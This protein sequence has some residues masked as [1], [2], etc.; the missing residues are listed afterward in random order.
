MRRSWREVLA[1]E[2]SGTSIVTDRSAPPAG[3]TPSGELYVVTPGR[4]RRRVMK[5][6]GLTI[7]T[8]DGPPPDPQDAPLAR[9]VWLASH[10]R[11]LIE[12]TAR[13]RRTRDGSQPRTLSE[14]EIGDWIDKIASRSRGTENLL[15]V[16]NEIDRLS[17]TG[18]YAGTVP[19]VPSRLIGAAL[20]T[21]D[22]ETGSL[23][24]ASRI[25]GR[26][27]DAHRVELFDRLADRLARTAPKPLSAPDPT[28]AQLVPF[29]EAYFSNFIEG[30][31][32]TI[33]E[34]YDVVFNGADLDRPD[35]A[36]DVRGTWR[37]TSN[38]DEMSNLA[39]T[40]NEFCDM[41]RRRHTLV[42]SSRTDK[43]PGEFKDRS[44]R[45]GGI[46]FVA[47]AEVKETLRI[48]WANLDRIADSF[49]RACY[50]MFLIAEV[51]PFV[52]GNGRVARLF[53]N[54]ELVA[55]NQ[56][57]VIIPT[58]YRNNYLAALSGVSHD[59]NP[60]ALARVLSFA[61]QWVSAGEWDNRD[62]AERYLHASDAY[63]TPAAEQSGQARLRIPDPADLHGIDPN[64][65]PDSKRR[66]TAAPVATKAL[67]CGIQTRNMKGPCVLDRGHQ[68]GHSSTGRQQKHR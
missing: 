52:D 67:R 65:L 32:F 26:P 7:L 16:R 20:G 55:A 13:S 51:H 62:R 28:R 59:N 3:P 9:N 49:Q 41:L 8:R 17:A 64:D 1:H 23:R 56:P 50:T 40:S 21:R 57:R 11:A 19:E 10:A 30:T 2:V 39:A 48:G 33:D 46:E 47:P 58:V 15:H 27:F 38:L 36:H 45:V 61:Q 34:A 14:T 44:N 54:A 35:D 12:N 68:N 6:P 37:V 24:L 18:A 60:D 43:H 63:E 53:M 66:P 5:L 42:M 29:Y 4:A 31:E 25:S 22:I